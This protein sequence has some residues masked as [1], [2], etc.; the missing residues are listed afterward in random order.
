MIKF[1]CINPYKYNI[2]SNK[3]DYSLADIPYSTTHDIK[4]PF[5][6]SEFSTRKIIT[7][8]FHVEN[9]ECDSGIGYDIIIGHNLMLQIDPGD[10]FG[11]KILE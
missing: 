7:N 4:P 1:K 11:R 2:I 9:A 8:R 6:M 10:N 5:S 3:V